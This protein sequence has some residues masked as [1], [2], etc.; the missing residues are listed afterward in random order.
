MRLTH[1]LLATLFIGT[2]ALVLTARPEASAPP[3]GPPTIDSILGAP[4]AIEV[5]AA[6]KTDRVA[7]VAYERG[8]R[9]V[10]TAGAPTWARP[11]A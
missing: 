4:S 2:F 11:C 9:N 1:R 7:W 5:V 6:T 3:S 10:Y 8:K